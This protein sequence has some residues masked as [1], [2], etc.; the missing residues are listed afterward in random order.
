M[1]R[2]GAATPAEPPPGRAPT[3]FTPVAAA[4]RLSAMLQY[5]QIGDDVLYAGMRR[6]VTNMTPGTSEDDRFGV[7]IPGGEIWFDHQ[8][9]R[10]GKMTWTTQRI[11][12]PEAAYAVQELFARPKPADSARPR[13]AL[14]V[15]E[16]ART[17]HS[18]CDESESSE[19]DGDED[20]LLG[21]VLPW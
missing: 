17:E 19:S 16:P 9:C 21:S 10:I 7:P 20:E 1:Y 13:D 3:L 11:S 2:T 5:V 6:T 8:G 18:P 14:A 15:E 4:A 12:L